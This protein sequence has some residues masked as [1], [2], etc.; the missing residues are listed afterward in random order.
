MANFGALTDHFELAATIGTLIGDSGKTPRPQTRKD[1][2]DKNGDIVDNAWHGNTAGTLY[3]VTN[4]YTVDASLDLST[5]KIGELDTGVVALSI[6]VD[7]T[8][9]GGKPTIEVSGVL[10]TGAL[11]QGKSWALPAITVTQL[12]QAQLMGVTVTTGEL[13][14]CNLSASCELAEDYDGLGEPVAH[15]VRGAM[16]TASAEAGATSLESPV[17]AAATGWTAS[18][19]SSLNEPQA[20]WHKATI[21]VEQPLTVAIAE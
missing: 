13:V 21:A 11:E 12:F 14:S 18:T 16:C 15:G 20:D 3:D 7:T 19:G 17:L 10:G 6:T 4:K 2:T 9:G 8:N 1:A 5:L